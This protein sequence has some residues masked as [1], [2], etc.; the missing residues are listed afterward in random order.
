MRTP[1]GTPSGTRA[2]TPSSGASLHSQNCKSRKNEK[3]RD[4][5][6]AMRARRKA[7]TKLFEDSTSSDEAMANDVEVAVEEQRELLAEKITDSESDP[8]DVLLPRENDPQQSDDAQSE[9]S[10][11]T[12]ELPVSQ[13]SHMEVTEET[14]NTEQEECQDMANE[15]ADSSGYEQDLE[16]EAEYRDGWLAGEAEGKKLQEQA[17]A[18]GNVA[19]G[20]YGSHQIGKEIDKQDPDKIAKDAVKSVNTDALKTLEN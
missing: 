2:R 8:C 13:E 18:A 17:V 16:S 19:A 14:A 4:R 20:A 3:A 12:R 10:Y 1:K 6:R 9:P 15:S 7:K 5:M 11:D